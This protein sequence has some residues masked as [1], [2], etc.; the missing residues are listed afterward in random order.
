MAYLHPALDPARCIPCGLCEVACVEARTGRTG[1]LPDD[2]IVLEQ[3]RLA[4]RVVEDALPRLDVCIHCT[5]SPCV[6]VCPHHALVRFPLHGS[7]GA[8]R[9]ELLESRCTGCGTC[10]S[11]CPYGAIRRVNVLDLAVKC[12]GCEGTAAGVP[13]CAPACPHG[14]LSLVDAP[15]ALR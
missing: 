2:V 3:R 11:A 8:V 5:E 15:R 10:V 9:V 14:A 12:D 13:A 7:D 4:I 1:L 6:R